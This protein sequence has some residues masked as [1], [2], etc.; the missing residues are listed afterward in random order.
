MKI[1]VFQAHPIS[2]L[3]PLIL[4]LLLVFAAGYC[5]SYQ[6]RRDRMR[7]AIETENAHEV[8][9]VKEDFKNGELYTY[10]SFYLYGADYLEP[11]RAGKQKILIDLLSAIPDQ[12]LQ[13]KQFLYDLSASCLQENLAKE[14]DP[15]ILSLLNR[16]IDSK[17]I[18]LDTEIDVS[19]LHCLFDG[20]QT[21]RHAMSYHP[22]PGDRFKAGSTIYKKDKSGKW[23]KGR[24]ERVCQR[25]NDIIYV[26]HFA[27]S[28]KLLHLYYTKDANAYS[29]KEMQAQSESEQHLVFERKAADAKKLED[30]FRPKPD[31]IAAATQRRKT[32]RMFGAVYYRMHTEGFESIGSSPEKDE[33]AR[34]QIDEYLE[35]GT[36]YDMLLNPL[37][38]D[39]E[40]RRSHPLDYAAA[41][42]Y[43]ALEYLLSRIDKDLLR[44]LKNPTAVEIILNRQCLK[45]REYSA[46]LPFGNTGSSGR[47]IGQTFTLAECEKLIEKFEE[48]KLPYKN[49]PFA[50]NYCTADAPFGQLVKWE[51]TGKAD[52][53]QTGKE[54]WIENMRS[55]NKYRLLSKCSTDPQTLRVYSL[56]D[57][58]ELIIESH[59]LKT[60]SEKAVREKQLARADEDRRK[61]EN[62]PQYAADQKKQAEHKHAAHVKQYARELRYNESRMNAIVDEA[63]SINAELERLGARSQQRHFYGKT[64]TGSYC[65][66][67]EMNCKTTYQGGGETASSYIGRKNAEES[68]RKLGFRLTDLEL[69]YN[70]LARRTQKILQG[71]HP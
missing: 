38:Q 20:T 10:K 61:Y 43:R 9:A 41:T 36:I 15:V 7:I 16:G 6:K 65:T 31:K 69:E 34:K 44:S 22:V 49:I 63:A 68:A 2:V 13:G 26:T 53:F 27:V 42:N 64:V 30:R 50:A 45:K 67:N 70:R 39:K 5:T 8:K 29:E 21:Q 57:H 37:V 54:Y 19:L 12:E 32:D 1:R 4:S 33:K 62:S 28:N 48:L 47:A 59:I 14:C 46:R 51:K 58:N 17:Y 3:R 35:D 18:F 24:I 11:I 71:E 52:K 66:Q 40:L 56:N 23:S 60:D 55:F 25:D